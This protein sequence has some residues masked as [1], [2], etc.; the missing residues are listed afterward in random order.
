MNLHP[1]SHPAALLASW[2][3]CFHP[4]HPGEIPIPLIPLPSENRAST[5]SMSSACSVTIP[6]SF[7]WSSPLPAAW[8][9]LFAPQHNPTWLLGSLLWPR[10]QICLPPRRPALTL[11]KQLI[12]LLWSLL[13]PRI[14]RPVNTRKNQMAKGK[15]KSL[16]YRSQY[17]K[18]ALEY[19]TL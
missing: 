6:S 1:I 13:W 9:Q 10:T 15:H 3:A 19:V 17:N 8:D 11:N 4:W 14:T 2:E 12:C 5:A 16:T 7:H 18:E